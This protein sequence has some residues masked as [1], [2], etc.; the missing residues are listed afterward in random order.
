MPSVYK[1]SWT[2]GDDPE[3]VRADDFE[4]NGDFIDFFQRGSSGG[5]PTTSTVLRVRAEKVRRID[6]V[7]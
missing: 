2:D 3:E 5:I 4:T 7:N 1:I 6:K